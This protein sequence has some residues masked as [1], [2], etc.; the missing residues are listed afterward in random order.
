M[1]LCTVQQWE[2][3]PAQ[4][5]ENGCPLLSALG[6]CLVSPPRQKPPPPIALGGQILCWQV[7]VLHVVPDVAR[8]VAG[9]AG[10]WS[11]GYLDRI[12]SL[13]LFASGWGEV[14]APPSSAF[15]WR[16]VFGREE[17]REKP[18]HLIFPGCREDQSR[19][20]LSPPG[21]MWH[22]QLAGEHFSFF[23][24]S[25]DRMRMVLFLAGK[26]CAQYDYAS[27]QRQAVGP[28]SG[29]FGLALA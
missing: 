20:C 3:L 27:M 10:G 4:A 1:F 28:P 17:S 13:S 14:S 7:T 22:A 6:N 21:W 16:Q 23:K 12:A 24:C 8:N 5:A 2:A 25:S 18:T 11:L 15:S 9:W 29:L 19:P 26:N